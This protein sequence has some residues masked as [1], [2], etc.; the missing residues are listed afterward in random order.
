MRLIL[1]LL[2]VL[3]ILSNLRVIG[4]FIISRR[5]QTEMF[6][7]KTSLFHKPFYRLAFFTL[8]LRIQNHSLA[9]E[10]KHTKRET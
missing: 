4:N 6:S 5:Y 3:I 10:K 7:G 1:K 2:K 9:F 8:Y